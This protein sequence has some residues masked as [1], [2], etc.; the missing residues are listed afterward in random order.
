MAQ[1]TKELPNTVTLCSVCLRQKFL[2]DIWKN[3]GEVGL[4]PDCCFKPKQLR[5]SRPDNPPGRPGTTVKYS[6]GAY[7]NESQA[8]KSVKVGTVDNRIPLQRVKDPA[9]HV[10]IPLKQHD[11]PRRNLF[12]AGEETKK[13][14]KARRK[15]QRKK[16]VLVIYMK[17]GI[18]L[19]EHLLQPRDP[20]STE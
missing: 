6:C 14:K 15:A 18:G 4:V 12:T 8:Y 20:D 19:N 17:E 13:A 10:V 9:R 3:K 1:L 11:Q 16:N 5:I 7:L 2:R